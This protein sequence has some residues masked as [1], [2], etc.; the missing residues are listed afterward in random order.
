VTRNV[1]EQDRSTGRAIL[2]VFHESAQERAER[3]ADRQ[4]Q[5]QRAQ[6]VAR[7]LRASRTTAAV[8]AP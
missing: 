1:V 3:Q 8:V 2:T 4:A 6:D 7:S 5:S